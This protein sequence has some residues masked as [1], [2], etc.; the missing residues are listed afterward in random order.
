MGLTPPS[1]WTMLKKTALFSRDG[2]PKT[3]CQNLDLVGPKSTIQPSQSE[4]KEFYWRRNAIQHVIWVNLN[5]ATLTWHAS[6]PPI[7]KSSPSTIWRKSW[8]SFKI[9]VLQKYLHSRVLVPSFSAVL[10]FWK[11]STALFLCR[12][13][14]RGLFF[15]RSLHP[16]TAKK[17]ECSKTCFFRYCGLL[18]RSGFTCIFSYSSL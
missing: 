3:M 7:M 2:F 10:S 8:V 15:S 18:I 1:V 6:C 9:I 17:I 12:W 4:Y 13:K 16:H 11:S 5:L 14:K